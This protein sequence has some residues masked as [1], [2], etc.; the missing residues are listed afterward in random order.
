MPEKK[1]RRQV[2]REMIKRQETRGRLITLS[3]ITLAAALLVTV[4]V[5]PQFKS[6]GGIVTPSAAVDYSQA[7]G[8]S[9]GDPNAPVTVDVFE[10]LQCPACQFFTESVEPLIVQYLVTPGKVRYVF[11]NYPFL[12]GPGPGSGGESDQAANAVMCANEQGRFWELHAVIYANWDGENR[13]NL[14]NRRLQAM[15][16][17]AGMEM[18]TF[19][20]CFS[21]NKYIDELEADYE[22]AKE[23][24]VSGTPSV[25]VNGLSVGG[26]GK[27]PTF[28][29]VATAV[30]AILNESQ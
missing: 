21:A 25:F 8:V 13:G 7:D 30:D 27:I 5:Y 24:G 23:F 3:L 4:F 19:D 14:S 12:D 18:D 15:A 20:A 10:D 17:T 11:H 1:S 28:Q 26:E 2:R 6:I 22:L 29:D 16:E 9:L